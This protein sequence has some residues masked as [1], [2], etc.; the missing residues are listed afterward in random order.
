LTEQSVVWSSN[1]EVLRSDEELIIGC[2][3]DNAAC[4]LE[5]YN[6]YCN[7]LYAVCLR[8]ARNKSD[9]PDLLQD[10]FVKV[11]SHLSQYKG[12]GS[13]EGWMRTIMRNTALRAYQKQR[14]LFEQN[15]FETLPEQVIDTSVLDKMTADEV[16]QSVDK[17]PNGYRLVFNMVAIDGM[18]HKEV[19]QALNIE[20][21]TSRAQLTKARQYLIRELDKID[22]AIKLKYRADERV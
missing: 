21:A 7:K 20:E 4:Q 12:N 3:K 1:P 22:P 5:L 14:F 18:S 9:A 10:G 19:A 2:L 13:F 16:M 8:Y 11:F 6:R 15:G 17:L